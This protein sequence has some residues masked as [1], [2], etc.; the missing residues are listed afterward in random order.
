MKIL[1]HKDVEYSEVSLAELGQEM[2]FDADYWEPSYL[3]NE[4]IITAKKHSKTKNIAPNPQY[5][6]SIAMNEEAN[7]YSILKMDNIMEMLAEDK[8]AKFADISEKTF[9]QFQL[10]K[11]D[12][13]FNRVNSDEFVGRTGIYLMDGK[14]TFA[15]YLVKVDSGKPYTN[16][17]L[18]AYLNCKYGKTALQRVKRRA[19]NQANINA[20]ELSNLN[21]PMPSDTLQKEIQKLIVEAQKQKILSEKLY[22]EAEYILLAELGLD[23]WKPKTK[24]FKL[25]GVEFEVEDTANHSTLDE[26]LKFDRIDSEYFEKHYY[27]IIKVLN[28]YSKV[29]LLK[30]VCAIDEQLINPK[31]EV[32]HK[33]IELANIGTNGIIEDYTTAL[34]KDLPTRARRLVKAN[35]VLVSSIEGSLSSCA[36]IPKELDNAF[37]STG[38]YL[39][40]SNKINSE[41]L[42][43]IFKLKPFQLLLKKACSGTI[44]TAV[45]RRFFK[46]LLIPIVSI[47]IQNKI[48]KK[49][50]DLMQAKVKSKLY[51]KIS[52]I[53]IE[54]FIEK[55]EKA[56]LKYIK[57]NT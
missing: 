42:L 36:L 44:L 20:K 29:D 27:E 18:T 15:S 12:V 35:Q 38:F 32:S 19:V 30:N 26:I 28:K 41:T 13:L 37:C 14:H 23:V 9:N 34:G 8:D 4:D 7:G 2:R 56:A 40:D 48:K 1:K 45:S 16:C 24:K 52:T 51:L 47:S 50:V 31:K 57:D 43:I 54:V 17:Y 55:D 49:V 21:I 33:Y 11:F 25:Y 22:H 39:I 5:G 53:A 46:N 3:K 10:K 6:I